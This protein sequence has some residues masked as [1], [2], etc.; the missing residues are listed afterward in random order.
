M[1]RALDDKRLPPFAGMARRGAHFTKAIVHA[2]ID[3]AL[4]FSLNNEHGRRV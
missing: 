2:V 3:N 1:V 4:F